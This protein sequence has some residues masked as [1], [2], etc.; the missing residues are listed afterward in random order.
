VFICF[1]IP[2]I[3]M[4]TDT[5]FD[6]LC[7]LKI[8]DA[9]LA[10]M[11][12]AD[13]ETASYCGTALRRLVDESNASRW[14][15]SRITKGLIIHYLANDVEQQLLTLDHPLSD[16]VLTKLGIKSCA[17]KH[18]TRVN[19]GHVRGKETTISL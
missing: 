2:V 15:V 12:S 4:K 3:Q 1:S 8:V 13:D 16:D 5:I 10:Q 11:K 17:E 19:E 18:E 9:L 6:A 7:D 14:T